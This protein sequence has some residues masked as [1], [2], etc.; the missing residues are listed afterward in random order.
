M[1]LN[2]MSLSSLVMAK[3]IMVYVSKTTPKVEKPNPRQPSAY[4][5][6]KEDQAFIQGQDKSL[7]S[8]KTNSAQFPASEYTG[9]NTYALN[10]SLNGVQEVIDIGKTVRKQA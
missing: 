2:G 9:A 5:S 8:N 6:P 3:R 4:H 7:K 10:E 1:G